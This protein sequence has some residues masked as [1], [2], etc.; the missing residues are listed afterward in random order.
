MA[1][2]IQDAVFVNFVPFHN[3]LCESSDELYSMKYSI[4]TIGNILFENLFFES[5]TYYKRKRSKVI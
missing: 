1:I 4:A 2:Q 3:E 5:V